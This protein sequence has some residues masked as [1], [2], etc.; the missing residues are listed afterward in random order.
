[1]GFLSIDLRALLSLFCSR[2][3]LKSFGKFF[4]RT[5]A[6]APESIYKPHSSIACISGAGLNGVLGVVSGL[7]RW[8]WD[9]ANSSNS[10]TYYP[11]SPKFGAFNSQWFI[12]YIAV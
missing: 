6:K 11:R 2:A 10:I 9:T 7:G 4:R 5:S 12:T 1:M 3:G 8:A